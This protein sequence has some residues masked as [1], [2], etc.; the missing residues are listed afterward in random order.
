MKNSPLKIITFSSKGLTE[1]GRNEI[2]GAKQELDTLT[3]NIYIQ[4]KYN[5]L[6]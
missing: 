1:K 3:T 5:H 2:K 6:K 4:C